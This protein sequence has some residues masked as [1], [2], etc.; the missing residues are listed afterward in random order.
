MKL[1]IDKRSINTVKHSLDDFYLEVEKRMIELTDNT[2]KDIL[3]D[4]KNLAPYDHGKLRQNIVWVQP[5]K[6]EKGVIQHIVQALMPYS[7]YQEFGT[8]GLVDVP[9]GW[10]DIAIQFKGKGKR[11]IN[12]KPQPFMYPAF[13]K[14]KLTFYKDAKFIVKYLTDKFNK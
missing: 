6:R 4:A 5:S 8:G 9:P 3:R 7:A 10:E 2:S 14:N 11:Q 1:T 12:M 13:A